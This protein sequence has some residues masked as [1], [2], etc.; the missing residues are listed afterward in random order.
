[1]NTT[2]TDLLIPK[3]ATAREL[4]VCSRTL[5]RWM[6]DPGLDFPRPII[7]RKRLYFSRQSL[8]EWKSRRLR[9]SIAGVA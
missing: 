2:Q 4:G 1:M 3:S 5:S 8:E 7:M 9:A 6:V